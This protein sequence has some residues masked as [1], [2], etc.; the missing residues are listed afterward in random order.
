MSH[1]ENETSN[2]ITGFEDLMGYE[3]DNSLG[4]SIGTSLSGN[5]NSIVLSA[6]FVPFYLFASA[7]LYPHPGWPGSLVTRVW[8]IAEMKAFMFFYILI[9]T[10]WFSKAMYIHFFVSIGVVW[11]VISKP[12]KYASYNSLYQK[13]WSGIKINRCKSNIVERILEIKWRRGEE[14]VGVMDNT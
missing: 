1:P 8:A 4:L 11:V 14:N 7:A 13:H 3:K 2:P 5:R 9:C 10:V 12:F 6:V